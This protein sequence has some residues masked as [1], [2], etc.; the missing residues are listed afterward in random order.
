MTVQLHPPTM[1]E[2]RVRPTISRR[3]DPSGRTP[4]RPTDSATFSIDS[5]GKLAARPE[6]A[7]RVRFAADPV[8]N[9]VWIDTRDDMSEAV[10]K[11]MYLTKD[12]LLQTRKEVRTI[13]A[14]CFQRP[15]GTRKS[16]DDAFLKVIRHGWKTG[17]DDELFDD[18]MQNRQGE[19]VPSIQHLVLFWE[20]RGYSNRGLE[21]LC[22][23]EQKRRR[24]QF[25]KTCHEHWLSD[26]SGVNDNRFYLESTRTLTLFARAVAYADE[27][28]AKEIYEQS[29]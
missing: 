9:I 4:P 24:T 22:S 18:L 19:L 5:T 10:T 2:C 11:D 21:R 16:L 25:T 1:E 28:V 17:S 8:S 7:G 26:T 27:L 13:I 29:Q 20:G 23:P 12:E 15:S 6:K 3:R 14:S